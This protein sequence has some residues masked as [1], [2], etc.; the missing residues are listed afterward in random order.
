M[1]VDNL[2]EV[3]AANIDNT[4]LVLIETLGESLINIPDFKKLLRLLIEV[5]NVDLPRSTILK[6]HHIWI[7]VF[8][9]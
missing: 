5:N 1:D 7:N 2:E 8:S 6:P 9:R 3:E 4:K